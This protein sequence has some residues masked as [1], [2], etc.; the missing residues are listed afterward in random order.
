MGRTAEAIERGKRLALIRV[1]LHGGITQAAFAE[2][3]GVSQA[4]YNNW[5]RGHQVRKIKDITPGIDADYIWWGDTYGLNIETLRRLDSVPHFIDRR[6][7]N[8][9][10]KACIK[11]DERAEFS[12]LRLKAGYVTR[13][14][15]W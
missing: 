4:R 7:L 3:L 13:G 15:L 10:K 8:R 6:R 11:A 5:E 2:R 1:R 14:P 12:F 9:L